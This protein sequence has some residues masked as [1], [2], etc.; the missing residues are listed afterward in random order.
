MYFTSAAVFC[1]GE[2]NVHSVGELQLNALQFGE[3]S[4]KNKKKKYQTPDWG[5]SLV[6]CA[7]NLAESLSISLNSVAV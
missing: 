5:G 3:F 2:S 1:F 7:S 6:N 4:Y